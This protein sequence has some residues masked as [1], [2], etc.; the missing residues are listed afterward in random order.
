MLTALAHRA[1]VPL[2]RLHHV[3]SQHPVF[4]PPDDRSVGLWRY[5]DFAKYVAM[6]STGALH[7]ARADTLGDPFEGSMSRANLERRPDWYGDGH[8]QITRA[9]SESLPRRSKRTYINCWHMSEFES[10]AMWSLYV[11]EGRGVAIR[12]TFDRLCESFRTGDRIYVGGVIYVDYGN[13]VIP[14]SNTFYPFM[15]KQHSYEHEREIRAILPDDGYIAKDSR[16]NP[17][18]DRNGHQREDPSYVGPPGRLVPVDLTSLID[19]IYVAPYTPDWV[20]EVLREVTERFG[21]SFDMR[22]SSLDE[23]P[24][25]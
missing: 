15:H 12:T 8:V 2:I 20:V 4:E 23:I 24:V 22:R 6:L 3:Y 11:H 16:G 7:F 10:A 13:D 1:L 9:F 21:Q 14:E 19:A 18:V 5:L 25:Y 17:I